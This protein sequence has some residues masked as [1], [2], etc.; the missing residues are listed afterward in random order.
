[1]SE[2]KGRAINSAASIASDLVILDRTLQ[3]VAKEARRTPSKT[4]KEEVKKVLQAK[5]RLPLLIAKRDALHMT[6]AA[7][8]ILAGWEPHLYVNG[9]KITF[10]NAKFEFC[11]VE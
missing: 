5:A 9:V 2:S 8:S 7:N 4:M 11:R 3:E 1:M 6:Y 10:C